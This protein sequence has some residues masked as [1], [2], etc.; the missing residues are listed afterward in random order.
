LRVDGGV[1]DRRE[2]GHRR[3]LLLEPALDGVRPGRTEGVLVRADDDADLLAVERAVARPCA[4]RSGYED[5]RR[6]QHRE[7]YQLQC[8]TPLGHTPSLLTIGGTSSAGRPA[9]HT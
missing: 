9:M 6:R 1:E 5:G 4:E 3:A 8:L 2:D 7:R